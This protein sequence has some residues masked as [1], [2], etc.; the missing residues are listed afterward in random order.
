[1]KAP[2]LLPEETLRRV[3]RL[4]RFD[5][6]TVLALPGFFAL[7]AASAGDVTGVIVGLLIAAA[8]AIELHGVDLLRAGEAR[9]MSWLVTS[10]FYLMTVV[11]IFCLWQLQ[12][13]DLHLLRTALTDEM[14]T[15]IAQANMSEDAFLQL[16]YR[17]TYRVITL[18]T[19]FYQGGMGLYYFRRRETVRQ[20]LQ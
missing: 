2:P 14:R 12:H 8:G 4:A 7:L 19:L 3:V 20:A 17:I 1:M 13:E 5:G 15:T 16:T 9:G 18:V 11:V 10:Q 6:L